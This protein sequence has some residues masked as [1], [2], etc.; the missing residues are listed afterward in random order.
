MHSKCRV[1]TREHQ[2]SEFLKKIKEFSYQD[3]STNTR[4]KN[5][6]LWANR[7]GQIYKNWRFILWAVQAFIY[8]ILGKLLYLVSPFLPKN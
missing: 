6:L 7:Q 8:V 4:E 3:M 2:A 1:A 5:A